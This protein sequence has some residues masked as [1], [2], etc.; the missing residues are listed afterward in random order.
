MRYRSLKRADL[1]VSRI[2]FGCEQLGGTDWGTYDVNETASAIQRA[3]DLGINLFDTANVYGLGESERALSKALGGRRH[4]MIIVTKGGIRWEKSSS[5]G[6]ARTF[7]DLSRKHLRDAVEGSLSRLAI[8]S[9][10]LYFLHWPDRAVPIEESLEAVRSMKDQ[11]K[12]RAIGL[13]NFSVADIRRAEESLQIDAVEFRYNLLDRRCEAELLPYC[14]QRDIGVFAYGP[15]AEGLLAGKYGSASQFGIDDRRSR[16]P[17]FHGDA[18]Q[19]NLM[20]VERVKRVAERR[21]K[22][23]V[24]VAINWVLANCAVYSAVVGM[25]SNAQLDDVINSAAWEL[26][27][28]DT[29]L[30]SGSPSTDE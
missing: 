15:L 8:D 10:P 7:I 14:V 28:A 29:E 13:S 17:H 26:D 25:K 9:I 4:D 18:L 27:E 2:G 24:Q 12:I 1:T 23:A 21:A 19:G 3:V 22:T 16:L 5:Q 6:R 30:L 11:G 20:V